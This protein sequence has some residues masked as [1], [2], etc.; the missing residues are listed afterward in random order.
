AV[1]RLQQLLGD[2]VSPAVSPSGPSKVVVSMR[3][4]RWL[5]NVL[6]RM[7]RKSD[8]VTAMLRTVALS[9]VSLAR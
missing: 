7:R 8:D 6:L 5:V 3:T 2:T 9:E 1:K 4:R